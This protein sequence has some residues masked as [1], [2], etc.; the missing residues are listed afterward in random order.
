MASKKSA[1]WVVLVASKVA[2]EMRMNAN[3]GGMCLRCGETMPFSLPMRV[4]IVNAM[5]ASF[6]KL[7][8]ACKPNAEGDACPICLGRGH[9]STE[10]PRA[11]ATTPEQWI[12]GPDTG[13]SSKTIWAVMMGNVDV[14]G[15][16]GP[17]EPVDPSDFGRCYR[18]L[19]AFPEWRPRLGEVAAK[20][21]RWAELVEAWD[22]L[23]KLYEEEVPKGHGRAPKLWKRM[24][25]LAGLVPV[26]GSRVTFE[27][28][29]P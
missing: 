20:Y 16:S 28:R 12:R 3:G 9:V 13:L 18:L 29:G 5:S 1:D 19:K 2:R 4:E 7:H 6:E 26:T 25:E 23:S 24:Q 11:K 22:E 15:S 10:C 8:K 27:R 17:R 21:P 14:L